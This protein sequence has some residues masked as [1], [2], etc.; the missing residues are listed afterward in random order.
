MVANTNRLFRCTYAGK[1]FHSLPI[2]FFRNIHLGDI[3]EGN[4]QFSLHIYHV[5]NGTA[6]K[7]NFFDNVHLM[8]LAA[9]LNIAATNDSLPTMVYDPSTPHQAPIL[10]RY[11]QECSALSFVVHDG[12]KESRVLKNTR[13][14][15]SGK[16]GRLFLRS[17]HCA[18]M[19][20]AALASQD[21]D[22]SS[23]GEESI[24]EYLNEF[25]ALCGLRDHVGIDV[26]S[27]GTIAKE[28]LKGSVFV[29]ECS[30][31]KSLLDARPSC[32][33]SKQDYKWLDAWISLSLKKVHEKTVRD[34]NLHKEGYPQDAFHRIDYGL[35]IFPNSREYG[36]CCSMEK[37]RKYA[38]AALKVQRKTQRE[39]D[40]VKARRYRACWSKYVCAC[41]FTM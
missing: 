25:T 40:R 38:A 36:L 32:C 16:T 41:C 6:F 3:T 11:K 33:F 5:G 26:K 7:N 28:F 27:M 31:V 30:G 15:I 9:A 39:I 8:T 18:L 21:A 23:D 22:D 4:K 35:Q 17:F 20:I 2:N 24:S 34:H 37:A 13:K 12:K 14:M 19:K 29:A 1:A 10:L